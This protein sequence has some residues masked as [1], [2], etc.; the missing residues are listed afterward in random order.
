MIV[1]QQTGSTITCLEL[2]SKTTG[3]TPIYLFEI[4]KKDSKAVKRTI[5]E[6]TSVAPCRYQKFTFTISSTELPL[7][8]Q[9]NLV[10]GEYSYTVYQVD[11]VSLSANIIKT[12]AYGILIVEG[13]SSSI[14]S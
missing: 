14:Y 13:T 3:D 1:L 7:K 2:L 9:L 5:V 11:S 4:T 12:L 6:D 10:S 8:G